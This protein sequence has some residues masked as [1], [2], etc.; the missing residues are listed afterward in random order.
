MDHILR[1][2]QHNYAR[3]YCSVINQPENN[4][5]WLSNK[6]VTDD[7]FVDLWVKL[8]EHYHHDPRVMFQLMNELPKFLAKAIAPPAIAAM[9]RFEVCCI[10]LAQPIVCSNLI[11]D[12]Q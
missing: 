3:W 6:T 11:A 7:D 4:L 5:P 1:L 8:A 2:C 12:A 9:L 10:L